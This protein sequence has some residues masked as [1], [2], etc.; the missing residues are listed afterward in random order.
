MDRSDFNVIL[1]LWLLM[2]LGSIQGCPN[3]ALDPSQY[4]Q[5]S[6]DDSHWHPS[7][8]PGVA[9]SLSP[10]L[11]SFNIT[12]GH[13]QRCEGRHPNDIRVAAIVEP[14]EHPLLVPI[15]LAVIDRLPDEWIVQI[16]HGK[17]NKEFL[18]H[19]PL[20][21][22]LI[23]NGKIVLS[24]IETDNLSVKD[25]NHLLLNPAFWAKLLG[26]NVLA[27][28]VDSVT[29]SG[30]KNSIYDFEAYDYIGAPWPHDYGCSI[31]Q[32]RN[33]GVR[34][35][36][37]R[38]DDK[39]REKYLSSPDFKF[40]RYYPTH[41]GNSGF[42]FKKRSK[43]INLLHSYVPV[44]D[45]YWN[46]S[47][48]LFIGCAALDPE[49]NMRVPSIDVAKHFSVEGIYFETPFGM[50]KP[51]WYLTPTQLDDLSVGCPEFKRILKPYYEKWDPKWG[52]QAH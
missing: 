18:T 41:I 24:Q 23:A 19:N 2:L 9:S 20:I 30:S 52:K 29:C 26:E 17:K 47:S 31:F 28:E 4:P 37:S 32:N 33:T 45:M 34:Y 39:N 49:A 42:S 44:S 22:P 38:W 46:T 11:L 3:T 14:R 10:P 43:M 27:F 5:H 35:A 51:W 25:Y 8:V 48:D 50:H 21:V 12:T 36:V 13:C 40:I 1:V 7:N 16:F 6:K 15:I